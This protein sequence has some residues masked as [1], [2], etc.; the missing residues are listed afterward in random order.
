[1]IDSKKYYW[2][3]LKD[4]FFRDKEIKKL[5]KVAGGD[6]YTIIYLKLQLL[7]L[8][9][10]GRLYFDNLEETLAE[11]LALE[12][13]EDA[14]NI[15]ITLLFLQKCGL[16]FEQENNTF[17][18]PQTIECIG[19]ETRSAVRVRRHREKQKTLHCNGVVTI[20]N[21]EKEIEKKKE[22]EKKKEKPLC[23][24]PHETGIFFNS[25]EIIEPSFANDSYDRF[26]F[27]HYKTI[28]ELIP[29]TSDRKVLTALAK[30][31]L[32]HFNWV[33]RSR[34]RPAEPNLLM[35]RGRLASGATLSDCFCVNTAKNDEWV[36]TEM[37][38]YIRIKTF[39]AASNFDQ[40]LGKIKTERSKMEVNQ[41]V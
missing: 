40:Y 24:K 16:I 15:K 14:E 9:T 30:V 12:I 11:E 10:E 8:R 41:N 21:V 33:T 34:F 27:E 28:W 26:P 3:R 23:G 31:V 7:S 29:P 5:R 2:L 32:K 22:Q 25:F 36:N 38:K 1:M 6:T 17:I 19:G 20:C 13:D 18:L 4:D 35:I 39:Y 37:E